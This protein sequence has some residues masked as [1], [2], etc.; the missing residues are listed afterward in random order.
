MLHR[1]KSSSTVQ[2]NTAAAGSPDEPP[3][4]TAP[5]TLAQDHAPSVS[6]LPSIRA[7]RSE[8]IDAV[9]KQAL[10]VLSRLK[11]ADL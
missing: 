7:I 2:E 8:M 3:A 11:L 9:S 5:Q 6:A 10:H 4:M 1:P